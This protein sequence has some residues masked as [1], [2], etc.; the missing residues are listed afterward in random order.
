MNYSWCELYLFLKDWQT[1]VGALLALFAAMVTILV[2]LCQAASEKKRH[3]NQLSRKKMAARARMP[4]ALSGI[5]GYV[6]EVGRFL[7]GQTD[8]RPDAPTSSIETLKQVIE[9]IDDDASARSFELVSWYQVQRARMQG[10]DNPQN[11]TGLLY[12]I[13]LLLAY[14][15]SLFDYAR[16]ETQ[17]VSNERFSRDEMM[18]A[19][20]NTFDLKYI[21]GHEGQFM[22]LDERIQNRC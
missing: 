18:S 4:D 12:D 21:L 20:N 8:E 7:T 17:T 1:L 11:D 3:R 2:M 16:N 9:H 14:V 22:Q 13:V 6:R 5:S 15:N 19:R 10:N